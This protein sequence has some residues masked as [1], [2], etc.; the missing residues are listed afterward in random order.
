MA[1]GSR[2]ARLEVSY[3]TKPVVALTVT[4]LSIGFVPGCSNSCD[5]LVAVLAECG[6]VAAGATESTRPTTDVSTPEC[7][8]SDDV[9]AACILSSEFDLC[10]SFGE[11]LSTCQA[12]GDCP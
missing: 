6:N 5:E 10:S 3:R 12:S 11:A 2:A 8:A 1:I 7:S 9:C 4:L